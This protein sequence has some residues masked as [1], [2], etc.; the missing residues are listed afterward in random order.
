[1]VVGGVS[2]II[3]VDGAQLLYSFVLAALVV[4]LL[5]LWGRWHGSMATTMSE[6]RVVEKDFHAVR[7]LICISIVWLVAHPLLRLEPRGL[8]LLM[9]KIGSCSFLL[10]LLWWKW[11][12]LHVLRL[13]LHI[14]LK[15]LCLIP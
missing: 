5:Q 13:R 9:V 6:V 1:M 14:L 4:L 7:A 11:L 8:V 3:G 10:M 12:L 15:F 2:V